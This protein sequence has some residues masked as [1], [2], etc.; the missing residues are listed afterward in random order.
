MAF[1]EE[2]FPT[3]ISRGSSGGPRRLTEIVSLRGG[4]EE[5]NSFWANSLHTFDAGMG[6]RDIADLYAVKQF[7]EA[8]V[9]ML[10]GFRFKDWSDYTSKGPTE[11]VN[12]LDV[13]I[14]TG[15][16]STVDFQLVKTYGDG[17]GSYTRTISKPVSGTV[18][19]AINGIPTT[20]FTVDT[21]TGIVTFNS[22]PAASADVTAGF[23]FDVPVR[24]GQDHI[25]INVEQFNA[26]AIPDI[27]I[28]ELR[29]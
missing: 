21:T 26:G 1:H 16:G 4:F 27:P 25:D 29:L 20:S 10:H 22:A 12:S 14:G 6:L 15:D 9:G 13:N 5:R 19:C 2:Q 7:F 3:A 17:S 24:F 23:E 18:V 28:Q 11:T 8:R